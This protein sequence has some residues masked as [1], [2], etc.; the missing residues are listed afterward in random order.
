MAL[1]KPHLENPQLSVK[2]KYGLLTLLAML[3][4]EFT[5]LVQNRYHQ[6]IMGFIV[7]NMGCK[8]IKI[9][10][11]SVQCLINFARELVDLEETRTNSGN[12]N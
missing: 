4:T 3:C 7:N 10:H 2:L 9:Q 1:I 12:D 6:L 5:P 8:E 11:R